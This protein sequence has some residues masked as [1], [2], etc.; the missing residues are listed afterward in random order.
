VRRLVAN[1]FITLDG[2][3]EAPNEWVS[4]DPGMGEAINA[5][6]AT[7]DALLVG[8]RTYDLFAGSWPQRTGA[9]DPLAGW[10]NEVP[11]YVV[12]GT[13]PLPWQPASRVDGLV[14]GVRDLKETE[15]GDILVFGS[16][17]LVGSLLTEGLLDEL[18]LFVHPTV[19]GTGTRLFGAADKPVGLSL[20]G[21]TA[22][23]NGVLYLAYRPA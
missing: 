21:S 17:T 16:P 19:R 23:P 10:I 18:Q 1:L 22:Y 2:V 20:A 3:A 4:F 11:K 6:V 12:G 15:G 9:D 8:A 5:A 14:P 7:A 13:G